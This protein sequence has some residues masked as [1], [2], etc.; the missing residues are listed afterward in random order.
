[1]LD[2]E[3]GFGPLGGIERALHR[4]SKTLLLVLAVDLPHMTTQYL[5]KLSAQCDRLTGAVPKL[6]GH[7][8]PLAAIYPKRCHKFAFD[9]VANSRH[10]VVDFATACLREKAVRTVSVSGAD[11]PC[12]RNWNTPGDLQSEPALRRSRP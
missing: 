7:L 11:A 6:E 12:F 1:L 10:A 8:E 9:G 4:C 3:P 2:F 5:R